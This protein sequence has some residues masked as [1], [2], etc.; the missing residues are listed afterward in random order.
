[1]A[2]RT[3]RT[4]T[5]GRTRPDEDG[6]RARKKRA[7]RK[8]LSDTATGM[9]LEHGFDGVRV[10][11][12]A[13]ACGVSESTVFNYFPTKESLLLDRLEKDIAAFLDALEDHERHPVEAVVDTLQRSLDNL[14][15]QATGRDAQANALRSIHRFGALL[16]STAALRAHLSER[17]E[18]LVHAATP[19]VAVR[20][21]RPPDHPSAFIIAVALVG[22]WQVQS[23]AL[24]RYSAE[25]A[26]APAVRRRVSAAVKTAADTLNDG[27]ANLRPTARPSS[28]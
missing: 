21:Q 7:Q 26:S 11:Q 5:N 13:A 23:D 16:R 8:E 12:V 25:L 4:S 20:L 2:A 17:R 27:L 15:R 24:H 18:Q 22:L 19:L 10:A 28:A 6:L 9:F 14:L 1:M 3:P